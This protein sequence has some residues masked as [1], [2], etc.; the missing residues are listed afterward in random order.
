MSKCKACDAKLPMTWC[1]QSKK[2][3]HIRGLATFTCELET[4]DPAERAKEKA[5]SRARD[6]HLLDTGGLTQ[7]E[8]RKQNA[9]FTFPADR[10]EKLKFLRGR[11]QG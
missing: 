4:Y 8:L 11:N 3:V 9:S 10:R 7:E 1:V 6:Q 5:E 2:Y